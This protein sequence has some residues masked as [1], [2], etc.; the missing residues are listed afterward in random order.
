MEKLPQQDAMK[1]DIKT[2]YDMLGFLCG[3]T[4]PGIPMAAPVP[5]DSVDRMKQFIWQHNVLLTFLK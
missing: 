4:L 2:I 1:S 5:H 3:K